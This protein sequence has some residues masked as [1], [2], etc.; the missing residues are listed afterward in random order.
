MAR[1]H[2]HERR[3]FKEEEASDEQSHFHDRCFLYIGLLFYLFKI[4]MDT[5]LQ[6]VIIFYYIIVVFY[7]SGHNCHFGH[8]YYDYLSEVQ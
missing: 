8:L 1:V 2:T 4:R 6:T 3:V 5:V 7:S